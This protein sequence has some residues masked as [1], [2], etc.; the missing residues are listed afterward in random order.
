MSVH[1]YPGFELLYEQLRNNDETV[2]I[3]AK[4]GSDLLL[5]R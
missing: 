2:E 3:E 1:E 5:A 4:R